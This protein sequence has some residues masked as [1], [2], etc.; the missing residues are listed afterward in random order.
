[1]NESKELTK[2]VG[3]LLRFFLLSSQQSRHE[4]GLGVVHAQ[5]PPQSLGTDAELL[6]QTQF[7][8]RRKRLWMLVFDLSNT[9]QYISVNEAMAKVYSQAVRARSLNPLPRSFSSLW[10]CV[11]SHHRSDLL[12][13]PIA[14]SL[15]S[16]NR[17]PSLSVV[18]V[19]RHVD[20]TLEFSIQLL[21]LDE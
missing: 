21:R 17:P 18:S 9:H 15:H 3:L 20:S 4:F 19:Q 1:M 8:W 14:S 7:G 6:S 5:S 10:L 12:A 2:V 11:P 16:S 13:C